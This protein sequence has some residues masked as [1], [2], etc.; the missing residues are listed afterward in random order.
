[1]GGY[2][3]TWIRKKGAFDPILGKKNIQ[4][5]IKKRGGV[6]QNINSVYL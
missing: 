2:R 5:Q 4:A 3:V 6:L 1:M